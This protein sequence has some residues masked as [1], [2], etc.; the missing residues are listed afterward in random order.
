MDV[1]RVKQLWL[2]EPERQLLAILR[3]YGVVPTQESASADAFLLDAIR[4][5]ERLW[6]ACRPH[7]SGCHDPVVLLRGNYRQFEV[8]RM[9]E[10]TR[11]GLDL[12]GGWLRYDRDVK[13]GRSGLSRIYFAPPDRLLLVS[14]TELDAVERTLERSRGARDQIPKETG[15]LSM[16]M[17]PSGMARVLEP[18]TPQA[19]RWLREARSIEMQVDKA[20][21]ALTLQVTVAFDSN[22]R[23][24][25]AATAFRIIW[26]ALVK[27]EAKKTTDDPI[28][29]I[30]SELVLRLVLGTT[31]PDEV[32]EPGAGNAAVPP[33]L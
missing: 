16:V 27:H 11:A 19:A 22:E 13:L 29:V 2:R 33:A 26:S 4:R 21:G 28:E 32:L 14:M 3:D 20:S 23:A 10:K 8:R 15:M 12:G 30:G 17:R 24:V 25:R 18:R 31:A 9:L 6:V 7:A 1:E 5:A